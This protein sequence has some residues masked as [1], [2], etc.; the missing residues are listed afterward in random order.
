MIFRGLTG[1]EKAKPILICGDGEAPHQF[2][3]VD[4]AAK[5]FVGV[6][7]KQNCTGQIYNLVNR[8]F[9]TWEEHHRTAMKVLGKEVELV[10]VPL[11]TLTAIDSSRFSICKGIFAHN[12]YYSSDKIFRDVPEFAPTISLEEGMKQVFEC[13]DAKGTIPDSDTEVWEDKIIDAQLQVGR[14]IL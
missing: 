1:Y 7:G 8:G 9:T 4:D 14:I 10:G 5:G 2:M 12:C 3:H 6:I 11:K 13:M